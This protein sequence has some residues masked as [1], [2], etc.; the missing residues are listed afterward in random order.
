MHIRTI[1][2]VV[3]ALVRLVAL[4]IA[5]PLL[6]C[7][8][9][10]AESPAVDLSKLPLPPGTK[11]VAI[12]PLTTIYATDK[13]VAAA[14][15]AGWLMEELRVSLFAQSLGT[16]QPVSAKRVRGVLAALS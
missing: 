14:V 12:T 5:S 11:P 16:A 8:P 6:A 9:L 13:P 7:A 3:F 15:E 2:S 4:L 10:W 1:L